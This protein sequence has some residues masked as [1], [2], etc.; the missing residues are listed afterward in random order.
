MH[1]KLQ[2]MFLWVASR[3]SGQLEQQ[4]SKSLPL[5]SSPRAPSLPL[6]PDYSW[7]EDPSLF[8][9]PEDIEDASY[10]SHLTLQLAALTALLHHAEIFKHGSSESLE[11]RLLKH[12]ER[13]WQR[14]ADAIG[15]PFKERR[16]RVFLSYFVAASNL[17]GA[18]DQSTAV[19]LIERLPGWDVSHETAQGVAEWLHF[20]YLP[21][22]TGDYLGP[23]QPDRL[24]EHHLRSLAQRKDNLLD[25]LFRGATMDEAQQAVPLLSRAVRRHDE[26]IRQLGKLLDARDLMCREALAPLM[27]EVIPRVPTHVN[28]EVSRQRISQTVP[29]S[30]GH[31]RALARH[32]L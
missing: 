27:L 1:S 19:H 16:R 25:S 5:R 30:A 24:A 18:K 20:L 3:Q 7:T 29:D 22:D 13:Y 8:V 21:D 23:L 6:Y 14:A 26:L 32:T 17:F 28:S 11:G 12:E 4:C 9:E 10:N 15:L 31:C 2:Y